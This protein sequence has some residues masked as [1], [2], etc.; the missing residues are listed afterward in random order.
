[1]LNLLKKSA[2]ASRRSKYSDEVKKQAKQAILSFVALIAIASAIIVGLIEYGFRWSHAV[3]LALWVVYVYMTISGARSAF[4]T[5]AEDN[6]RK[7]E[8]DDEES[9]ADAEDS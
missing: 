6:A 2:E 1:M 5:Y 4:H 9:Q 8:S 7:N 3:L